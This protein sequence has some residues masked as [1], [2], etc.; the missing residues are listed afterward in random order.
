MKGHLGTC[1]DENRF[2]VRWLTPL[3]AAGI[4]LAIADQLWWK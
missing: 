3:K 2:P 4:A 1:K